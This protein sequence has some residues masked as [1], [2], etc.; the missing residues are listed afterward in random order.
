MIE[1]FAV[2]VAIVVAL[3]I[4]VTGILMLSAAAWALAKIRHL[5]YPRH[6]PRGMVGTTGG[7]VV[8][9]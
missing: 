4:I 9:D 7:A 2:F 1:V 8:V 3:G 5:L 6:S